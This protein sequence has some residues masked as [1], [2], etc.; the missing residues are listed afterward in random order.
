[1]KKRTVPPFII[2]IMVI[3]LVLVLGA[4]IFLALLPQLISI[5]ITPGPY[6]HPCS[7]PYIALKNTGLF[8]VT[9]REW[10]IGYEGSSIYALPTYTL[11]PGEVV[12]VW[13]RFGQNDAHNLYAGREEPT[14]GLIGLKVQGEVLHIKYYWAD[15]C[16]PGPLP[17]Q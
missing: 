7:T 4:I 11:S 5:A 2:R 12:Q 8:P 6:L 3:P 16:H 9:L 13:S 14:W 10:E 1:M 15:L 17:A